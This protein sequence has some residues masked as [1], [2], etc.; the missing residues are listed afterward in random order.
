VANNHNLRTSYNEK[1]VK[2]LT[3]DISQMHGNSLKKEY[4]PSAEYI[5]L[6][7]NSLNQFS[8]HIAMLIQNLSESIYRNNPNGCV[9]VS[10]RKAGTSIG[11]LIKRFLEKKYTKIFPHYSIGVSKK[12]ID[13]NALLYVLNNHKDRKIQFVDAWTG[14]GDLLKSLVNSLSEFYYISDPRTALAV[15]SDPANVTDIC[16]T[17]CDFPIPHS[18]LE[19][20]T[21]GL[22]SKAFRHLSLSEEDYYATIYYDNLLEQDLTYRFI[23]SV[24]NHFDFSVLARSK[25]PEC[26]PT[27]YSSATE[28]ASITSDFALG[29]VKFV[30]PGIGESTRSLLRSTPNI[31]LFK[32]NIDKVLIQHILYLANQKNIPTLEYPLEAYKT[33]SIVIEQ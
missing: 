1:D 27:K 19:S 22:L 32:K 16:G 9:L 7:I 3:T 33:C 31:V 26:T 17:H 18:F 29:N 4:H 8:F 28:I 2:I 21:S 25:Y 24:E 11:V 6:F 10:L 5:L 15:L 14:R 12:C 30:K 23:D 13:R 20:T